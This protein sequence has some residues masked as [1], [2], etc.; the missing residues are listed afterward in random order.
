M[1]FGVRY[2]HVRVLSHPHHELGLAIR[3]LR[4]KK[5]VIQTF[6]AGAGLAL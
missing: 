1:G 5:P 6:F 3:R 2:G 4:R